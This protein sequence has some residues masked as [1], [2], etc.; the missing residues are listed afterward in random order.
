MKV[1]KAIVVALFSSVIG[2][3]GAG[4]VPVCSAL[5][6]GQARDAAQPAVARRIGAIKAINGNAITLAPDSGSEVAV[7]VQ[8]NA[9]LLRIAPGE[10]D[11][12]NATPIQLQELQVGDTIRVRGQASEDAKSIAALEIIVITRSAVQAISD[13]MRQDWQKRGIGGPVSAVDPAA[14]TVSISI[15][16]FGGKSR[17]IVVHTSKSTIIRRYAPDSA[18]PEDAKLSGLEEATVGD[19]LRARGNRSPDGSE[20]AAEEIFT[21]DF[22]QFAGLIKSVD[23]SGGTISVQDLANK[24]TVQLKITADSQLHKIPDEMAK[25]MAMR[26]KAA[27]TPGT[28]GAAA[29]SSSTSPPSAGANGQAAPGGAPSAGAGMSMAPGSGRMGGGPRSG[30]GFDF[31]RLLDQ[32]PPVALA[33]LHKGDAVTVVTTQG[34]PSSGS[35]VIR[36][37]SGVEPILEAPNG[38]QAMML[39]PWSLGGPPGGDAGQQ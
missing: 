9:R 32:T 17:T 21:G 14:G 18:K 34:T 5:A 30:G 33:D 7:T 11:L 39:A 25:G 16:S 19:Q 36:L 10:K 22:P 8:P 35:T 27:S 12:K 13:Q 6:V 26:L 37:Y 23:A 1:N 4:F 29:N 15:P 24:K 31:Q 2:A 28:P 38:S 20:L 3:A